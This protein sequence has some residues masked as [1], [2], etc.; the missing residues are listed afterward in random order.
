MKTNTKTNRRTFLKRTA[1]A[2]SVAFG[3]P[4]IVP[5]SVLGKDGHVAASERVV[6]GSIGVG[7]MGKGDMKGLMR[8]DGVQIVAVCD[9]FQ[10]RREAA[11]K[12]A[13]EHYD[14]KDCRT[15][16]DFR[17]LLARK[18]IDAVCITTQ[19]HWHALIATAA[20]R[21]GKHIYCQKP[22]GM[23]VQE[24][25][26]IRSAVRKNGCVFQTGTQQRSARNFR[27]ACELARNGYVGKLHTIEV[28]APG[29]RY[30][31]M[32]KKP[33]TPESVPE[34]FDFDMFTGPAQKRPYNGGLWAW[35]DWY[36]IRDYCVGFIVNWGVHHLDIAN[37]GCPSVTSEPCELAF[38]GHYRND[39]LTDNI[40]DWTGA[41]R[42]ESGLR[43]TY[44]DTDNPNKQGC[45]FRGDEGWVHVNRSRFLTEPSSLKDVTLKPGEVSL[46]AGA[47]G[48]HYNNFIQCVRSG[49]DPI[50]PVEAG[51]QAS[52]LGM[53]AEISIKLGRKLK[54][55]PKA[56]KFIGDNEANGLLSAPMR[57]PWHL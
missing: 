56:E 45:V 21:E 53:I 14:T 9:V 6:L 8:V 20:A 17:D 55:D 32:Y 29:P 4:C 1:S 34:G 57:A 40:N 12:M 46:L 30:K 51:H 25:Q 26:A 39:G 50:A 3:L 35:P 24:C 47:E 42:F 33:T 49:K 43:M 37:W 10:N 48:S 11:K 16:G 38:A 7:S 31:R 23:T 18:D 22:L 54:W 41:F 13:D 5:G 2:A 44:S 36:L 27:F 15:Y 52:Y 19:D 28:A